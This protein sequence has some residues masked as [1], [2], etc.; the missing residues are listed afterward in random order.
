[1]RYRF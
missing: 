1:L